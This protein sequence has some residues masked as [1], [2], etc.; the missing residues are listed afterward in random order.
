MT[1]YLRTTDMDGKSHKGFQWPMEVGA[2][3][4]AP[5]WSPEPVCGEGLHGLPNGLGDGSLLDFGPDAIWWIVEAENAVDLD[6]KHKFEKC[7]VLAFGE[8]DEITRAL[9]DMVPGPIHGISMT[10]GDD[11]T[12][13]GGYGA[14]LTGGD[15]ATLTGGDRATLTGGDRATL[16]GG[17]DATLTGGY[18]ATL[19]GGNGAT[20]TGG[21]R[22]TLTGGDGAT[23]TG[24]DGA[25]LT[26]GDRAT[27]TGGYGATLT[28]GDFSTLTGGDRATLLFLR[29]IRKRRRV[30]SAYVG[31]DGVMP[32]VPYRA[33]SSHTAIVRAD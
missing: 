23:L 16:T 19:T 12:L 11:A 7:R 13:T 26:G 32:N 2:E 22:A 6:G 20:L 30:L 10:G 4:A 24:G 14:T 5:D 25:T 15:R 1:L 8:R 31:E 28:G 33:N 27:L 29:W 18:R 3:V 21:D 17:D 9:H